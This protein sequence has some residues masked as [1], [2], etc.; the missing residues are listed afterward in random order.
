MP[1]GAGATVKVPIF[2]GARTRRN[3]AITD[4]SI[5][6]SQ[7]A[8]QSTRWQLQKDLQQ[9]A[10][11]LQSNAVQLRNTAGQTESAAA[12][13][14]ITA[15]RLLNGVATTLDLQNAATNVQRADLNRLQ[16]EYK[17]WLAATERQRLTGQL[18]R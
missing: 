9:N 11:E 5:N 18:I 7:L 1:Y 14:Q 4:A 12:A 3:L 2:D 10:I 17:L 6:Q 13:Q 8:L 15:S 16:Y